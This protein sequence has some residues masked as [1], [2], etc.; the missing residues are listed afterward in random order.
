[1]WCSSFN[2]CFYFWFSAK[3]AIVA[4]IA[5][6]DGLALEF[7]VADDFFDVGD[8]DCL[9]DVFDVGAFLAFVLHFSGNGH[10]NLRAVGVD[11]LED[12]AQLA[13]VAV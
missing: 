12:A 9:G 10:D 3:V 13:A 4:K 7:D 5:V 6:L 2:F 11:L 8:G 1:M